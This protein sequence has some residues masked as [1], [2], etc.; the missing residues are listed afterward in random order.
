[1]TSSFKLD[2]ISEQN[3]SQITT[4]L[5]WR[6]EV[7]LFQGVLAWI[8]IK[9]MMC[10]VTFTVSCLFRLGCMKRHRELDSFIH[11]YIYI[12]MHTYIYMYDKYRNIEIGKIGRAH[13]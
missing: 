11:P 12:C 13:V 8:W 2:C 4:E 6:F 3:G 10:D 7:C 5:S 1:M 9:K